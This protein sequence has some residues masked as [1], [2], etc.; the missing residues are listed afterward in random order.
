MFLCFEYLH[1]L[2]SSWVRTRFRKF[3]NNSFNRKKKNNN[4]QI[5][6]FPRNP[7]GP[8]NPLLW[9]SVPSHIDIQVLRT[10]QN[11]WLCGSVKPNNVVWSNKYS[12][13]WAGKRALKWA[14]FTCTLIATLFSL[15]TDHVLPGHLSCQCN[16]MPVSLV[17]EKVMRCHHPLLL[18]YSFTK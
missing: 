6:M 4:N 9:N 18:G 14:V 1:G 7:K 8:L 13:V 3:S 5:K 17:M 2:K 15:Q 10:E 16:L 11:W 12:N